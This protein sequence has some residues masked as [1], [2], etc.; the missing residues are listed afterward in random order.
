[1][2]AADFLKKQ[3]PIFKD[4]APDRLNQ[5]VQGSIVGSFEPKE[6]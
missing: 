1:V 3:V 4:F 2:D 6:A 5:V